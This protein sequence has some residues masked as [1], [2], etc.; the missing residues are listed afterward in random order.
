M[1]PE[2]HNPLSFT[3]RP[4]S[5][6]TGYRGA[7][8]RVI[9]AT[10]AADAASLRGTRERVIARFHP[11]GGWTEQL[12]SS[13]AIDGIYRGASHLPGAFGPR[14][15]R[16]PRGLA[17]DHTRRLTHFD[18]AADRFIAQR[19]ALTM[20]TRYSDAYLAQRARRTY[21]RTSALVAA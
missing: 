10:K 20:E 12:V 8:S 3:Y 5:I 7:A 17:A 1:T 15:A 4:D 18:I 13:Y 19:A 9:R 14:E 2:T 6:D 11:V 21:Y 16:D